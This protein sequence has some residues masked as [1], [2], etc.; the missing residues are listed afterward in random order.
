MST[1]NL[2]NEGMCDSG[3]EPSKNGYVD[4]HERPL[5]SVE[6]Y[7]RMTR[8]LDLTVRFSVMLSL[9]KSRQPDFRRLHL[10]FIVFILSVHIQTKNESIS[11]VI[12]L[13]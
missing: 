13:N 8:I 7:P 10:V 2:F 3:S 4:D 9:K 11:I 1:V 12:Y 6:K 5:F